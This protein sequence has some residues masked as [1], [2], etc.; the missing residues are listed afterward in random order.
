MTMAVI[1]RK[2]EL[3]KATTIDEIIGQQE[4]LRDES[5][6]VPPQPK[7]TVKSPKPKPKT[8]K[9]AKAASTKAETPVVPVV[10]QTGRPAAGVAPGDRLKPTQYSLP[11]SIT[12]RVAK[13]AGDMYAGNRSYLVRMLL[14][15]GLDELE[16][17]NN[18]KR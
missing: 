9:I 17:K 3:T 4:K 15:K 14:E 18:K 2:P 8:K 7:K 16:N 13:L 6:S 1:P 5:T 12:E 11:D 10:Q